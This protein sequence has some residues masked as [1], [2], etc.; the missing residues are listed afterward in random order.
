MALKDSR[1]NGSE[2]VCPHGKDVWLSGQQKNVDS[3]S[4]SALGSCVAC[5]CVP[6]YFI[7]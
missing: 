4:G 3:P 2:K 5:R 1:E 6:E 7:K